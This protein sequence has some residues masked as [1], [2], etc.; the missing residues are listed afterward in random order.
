MKKENKTIKVKRYKKTSLI[1]PIVG[2]A[3][4]VGGAAAGIAIGLTKSQ[5][6]SSNTGT[7]EMD[8]NQTTGKI[9]FKF[10]KQPNDGKTLAT[11][12]G[13]NSNSNDAAE[14]QV[15]FSN[16]KTL[17][18][19]FTV[20]DKEAEVEFELLNPPASKGEYTY[21]FGITF[22]YFVGDDNKEV[23]TK[24]ENLRINYTV[25]EDW[26]KITDPT[27]MK[28]DIP[29]KANGDGQG[30]IEGFHY[31]GSVEGPETLR[32][33]W[34]PDVA[35]EKEIEVT[36]KVVNLDTDD[37]SFDV[38]LDVHNGFGTRDDISRQLLGKLVF[39]YNGKEAHRTDL[40]DH[41]TIYE[42]FDIK[43][44]ETAISISRTPDKS[45]DWS[46][47]VKIPQKFYFGGIDPNTTY[48]QIEITPNFPTFPV[49][50][51]ENIIS[52]SIASE[53]DYHYWDDQ[54]ED[55][56]HR[57]FYITL[58]VEV[59]SPLQLTEHHF[60]GTFDIKFPGQEKFEGKQVCNLNIM[61]KDTIFAPTTLPKFV[62]LGNLQEVEGKT[63]ASGTIVSE[64]W[65]FAGLKGSEVA[66]KI[67]DVTFEIPH[68]AITYPAG[69]QEPTFTITP[70]IDQD[71]IDYAWESFTLNFNFENVVIDNGSGDGWWQA[72]I[73]ITQINAKGDPNPSVVGDEVDVPVLNFP[74]AGWDIQFQ[75]PDKVVAPDKTEY[76]ATANRSNSVVVTLENFGFVGFE[77]DDQRKNLRITPSPATGT[78]YTIEWA[79]VVGEWRDPYDVDY[80]RFDVQ[81]QINL[82][83]PYAPTQVQI[84]DFEF[85]YEGSDITYEQPTPIKINIAACLNVL[86]EG[87]ER[88][89]TQA[90]ER[91]NGN[92][93][94][95]FT[96]S[97]FEASGFK[98][99]DKNKLEVE[100]G[101]S[102]LPSSATVSTDKV[103]HDPVAGGNYTFDLTIT[104]NFGNWQIAEQSG[105]AY[106]QYIASGSIYFTLTGEETPMKV[107][108]GYNLTIN[109]A[110]GVKEVSNQEATTYSGQ[111]GAA[112]VTFAKAFTRTDT[113]LDTDV[114]NIKFNGL[115]VE[116]VAGVVPR[117]ATASLAVN[118][119]D[120]SYLDLT[121]QLVAEQ[122]AAKE[123]E[124]LII[125]WDSLSIGDNHPLPSG[126]QYQY[127]IKANAF[128]GVSDIEQKSDRRVTI[129]KDLDSD[130]TS[131]PYK[132]TFSGFKYVGFD[133][134]VNPGIQDTLEVAVDGVAVTLTEKS[135]VGGMLSFTYEDKVESHYGPGKNEWDITKF[136]F[137]FGSGTKLTS[138]TTG[139]GY[140]VTANAFAEITEPLVAGNS[141]IQGKESTGGSSVEATFTGFNIKK[142]GDQTLNVAPVESTWGGATVATAIDG[143]DQATG[144]FNVKIT[145]SV[146]SGVLQPNL[147]SGKLKFSLTEGDVTKDILNPTVNTYGINYGIGVT[148]ISSTEKTKTVSGLPLG[149]TSATVT[150]EG[151]KY[152]GLSTA[153]L[154][155]IDVDIASGF[156][157]ITIGEV[158]TN[159][160]PVGDYAG[161]LDL[162]VTFEDFDLQTTD[163]TLAGGLTISWGTG[164]SITSNNYSITI[165]APTIGHITTPGATITTAG[166]KTDD[167]MTATLTGFGYSN[168]TYEEIM[169]KLNISEA[170][171]SITGLILHDEGQFDIQVKITQ[172]SQADATFTLNVDGGTP[173]ATVACTVTYPTAEPEIYDGLVDI[174]TES[175]A[176]DS[177]T[178]SWTITLKEFKYTGIDDVTTLDVE[179]TLPSGYSL[180]GD[181]SITK[182]GD[183]K[184]NLTMT[185]TGGNPIDKKD[186]PIKLTID[187]IDFTY[188][189]KT[190]TC[191]KYG[192]GFKEIPLAHIG[193]ITAPSTTDLVE[194][195]FNQPVGGAYVSN[196]ITLPN[197][198]GCADFIS[199]GELDDNVVITIRLDDTE[200]PDWWEFYDASLDAS[201]NLTGFIAADLGW[202]SGDIEGKNL[203]INISYKAGSGATEKTYTMVE[204]LSWPV[205]LVHAV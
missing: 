52:A 169:G 204:N 135:F 107:S 35:F 205:K 45:L 10:N 146:A 192:E 116:T 15:V 109:P 108:S 115:E 26:I 118:T 42:A 112:N 47:D 16:S 137:K 187:K 165:K 95:A 78:N 181:P 69:Y 30:K 25:A 21:T 140:H 68:S 90:I 3:L 167:G 188:G 128:G 195:T 56:H 74:E 65:T 186:T 6:V 18:G 139:T 27:D 66:G 144:N 163:I 127:K 72:I 185:I 124:E 5:R 97:G 110:K 80:G 156:A 29:L 73:G 166:T 23:E 200:H 179:P 13:F 141:Y 94:V 134:S 8:P 159:I 46:I 24:V 117:T 14:T 104:I 63:V 7:I 58:H 12:T 143:Y 102:G 145:L 171:V 59:K 193:K 122:G 51:D 11:I 198:D 19:E 170:N 77:S 119:D 189:E 180:V 184:F 136:T 126:Q 34:E 75:F 202:E 151:F 121:I 153:E 113:L 50:A 101:L 89:H 154:N 106:Q 38:R 55:G 176:Y 152:R 4:L 88:T 49:K 17:E 39:Y 125:K 174:P 92:D 172:A 103:W 91:V 9:T 131:N 142:T 190:M 177:A 196:E 98:A 48:S 173:S 164:K 20:V 96:L 60:E 105:I 197:F 62:K 1:F 203:I 64:G 194:V 32:V 37:R 162:I 175:A 83:T 129:T 22:N 168:L 123:N 41:A 178:D 43:E 155:D 160:H 199:G 82:E 93:V 111:G 36:T 150:F 120:D 158:K 61:E 53:E 84:D 138:E 133:E 70:I 81:M 67:E 157:G 132:V 86:D 183:E 85:W 54:G 148:D 161:T 114:A 33:E 79:K 99:E 100:L 40:T 57:Y 149:A 147:Y 87:V 201:G 71:S 191:S 31:N 2:G 44:P 28:V 130:P 182:D 76:E